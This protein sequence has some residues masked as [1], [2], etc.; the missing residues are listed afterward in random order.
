M[1]RS[2]P[3]DGEGIMSYISTVT[4]AW[5]SGSPTSSALPVPFLHAKGATVTISGAWTNAAIG[6]QCAVIPGLFL[7]LVDWQG[8]YSGV[9]VASASGNTTMQAPPA[10][11][12]APGA[13][14]EVMLWSHDGTGSGV[15]QGNTRTVLVSVVSK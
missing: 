12:Y 7:P 1:R 14:N 4:A 2:Y 13:D 6:L 3:L 5:P 15:P 9:S 11:Y 10:W 8:G